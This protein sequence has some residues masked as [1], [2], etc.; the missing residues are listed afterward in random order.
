M[1]EGGPKVEWRRQFARVREGARELVRLVQHYLPLKRLAIAIAGVFLFNLLLYQTCGLRGCPDPARLIAYQPGGASELYDRHGKKFGDLAPV[2]R[3]IVKISALPAHVGA[4]FIAVEDK[5]FFRHKGIDWKRVFGAAAANLKAGGVTQGS[6]TITMQ[7]SRNIF[8][9]RL[10]AD[11]RSMRRKI[12]EARVARRIERKFS[13]KEILELYLNHIY[14]GG[15][16]YGVQAAAR[17]YFDKPASKLSLHEAALLAALPKAPSTYDPRLRPQRAKTRRDL[18]IGLMQQQGVV[19]A[20]E[21]NA[22]R[23]RKLGV[24]R[25]PDRFARTPR[26]AYFAHMIREQLERQLGERIYREKL[27]VY[28]TLDQNAQRALEEE[29]QRQAR[30]VE[31]GQYGRLNGPRYAE[32]DRVTMQGPQYLQGAGIFMET[33][34]GEVLALAGGRDYQHSPYN[35]A[36]RA[37]RQVGSAFKPFVYGAALQQGYVPSQPIMDSPYRLVNDGT[38]WEPRNFDGDFFGVVSM[39]EALVYSRNVPSVRLAAAVGPDNVASFAQQAGI[40]AEIKDNPMIALGI[41]EASPWEL[42][43]AY[44]SFAGMGARTEPRIVRKV[45]ATDGEVLVESVPNTEVGMRPEIAFVITDMLADAVDFG[46]GT[47]VRAAGYRGPAA[48]K[49]GTTS[50]GADVWFAG[51][52]PDLVGVM[53]FGFDQ[54]RALPGNATGGSVAAPAWGRI[55]NRIYRT[56]PMPE[57]WIVPE[58]VII[59][60]VDPASGLVLSDGCYPEQG[61][62]R[63]ELFLADEEPDTICPRGSGS[64][65]N[66]FEQLFRAVAGL[67]DEEKKPAPETIEAADPNLGTAKVAKRDKEKGNKGKNKGKGGRGRS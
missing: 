25:E 16:A 28:T 50:S 62:P 4:A 65:G 20:A 56:R 63:K 5:R 55:I 18:V 45:V 24:T 49:T 38:P 47:A 14:F 2:Q 26:G 64:G 3:E 58:N 11:D 37:R 59:R 10:R 54:R 42:L 7:L 35:R 57:R 9:D 15:G 39:R 40:T 31:A 8:S 29:M 19:T 1:S 30:A 53:W 27:R 66:L 34:T 44:A 61:E 6:S 51:Y 36:I 41:T 21:A 43:R 52:T 32:Y 23:E 17:Y 13:K 48:G 12:F 22:A 67:F 60:F 46:T 33:A